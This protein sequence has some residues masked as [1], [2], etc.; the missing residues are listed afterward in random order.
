QAE[1]RF[2]SAASVTRM[3]AGLDV[4]GGLDAIVVA[5][6]ATS[7]DATTLA[8][9]VTQSLR[10]AKKN[11]EILMLGLGPYLDG[12]STKGV[13]SSFEVRVALTTAQAGDLLDRAAAFLKLAREGSVPGF[14]GR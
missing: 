4:A 12:V 7:E 1:P 13:G 14:R 5:D 10:D 9:Q 6:L 3:A 8:G 2:K 11:P